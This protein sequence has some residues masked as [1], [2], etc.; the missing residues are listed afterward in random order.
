M[1]CRF[2]HNSLKH[3]FAD[4]GKSPLANSYLKHEDL[5]K[6]ESFYP[7]RTF[8]C[9]R[10]FLVQLEEFENPRKIFTEYVYFS[11]FSKTWLNHVKQFSDEVISR[12][13]LDKKSQ[14]IEIASNDGY[15]LKNFKEKSIS[16][17]GI[18]PAK[19]IAKIANKNGIPT[20]PKFFSYNF[21]SELVKKRKSSDLL[22]VFNVL[23]HVP[24]LNDFVKGLKKILK[25]DGV[26]VIQFSAYLLDLI[27]KKEFDTVYHEHF[28]YFSLLSLKKIVAKHNLTIFDAQKEK[29]HGGSLR[30][31][32]T[33]STNKNYRISKN[34]E[35]LI[36]KEKKFRLDKISTY[37][38]FSKDIPK[39]K[40]GIWN[41]FIT[42]TK[43]NKNIVCYGAPA[44]GNTLLNYCGIGHDFIE[45]TVDISPHKQGLYL[46]GSNIPILSPSKIKKT[47]PDYVIILPW[48]LKEEIMEQMSFITTWGG[49]FVTFIP[50]VRIYS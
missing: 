22:I 40:N 28:S 34:V 49:K 26:L 46:P 45:Y 47:K 7:L 15:L 25:K 14:V 12:F 20:L 9:T 13:G 16:V 29:I 50:K 19:N 37:T 24:K 23:P 39:I 17:L 11:S 33:H 48:N 41:F 27:N 44:K 35:K 30:V 10:C 18:E 36:L 31:F 5:N 32:V 8:V 1:N 43:M 3:V 6:K 42:A 38:K 21:A 4:L 2:C